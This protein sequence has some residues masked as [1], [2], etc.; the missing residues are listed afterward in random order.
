MK[1]QTDNIFSQKPEFA[2][3]RFILITTNPQNWVDWSL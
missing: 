2:D 3:L 1:R